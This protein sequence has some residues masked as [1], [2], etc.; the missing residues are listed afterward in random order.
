MGNNILYGVSGYVC[1]IGVGNFVDFFGYINGV[2]IGG[3]Y[4]IWLVLI[5]YCGIMN[6][7]IVCIFFDI[8]MIDGGSFYII[9]NLRLL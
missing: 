1:I 6:L 4:K 2:D 5:C 9:D 3:V 8:G 7:D